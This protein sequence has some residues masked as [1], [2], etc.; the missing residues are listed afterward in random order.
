MNNMSQDNSSRSLEYLS[1]DMLSII[2]SF[3][4]VKDLEKVSLTSKKFNKLIK[5]HPEIL[6]CCLR[7]EFMQNYPEVIPQQLTRL[8]TTTGKRKFLIETI[9][10]IDEVKVFID[11]IGNNT[12]TIYAAKKVLHY[13][14]TIRKVSADKDELSNSEIVKMVLK[15]H[16]YLTSLVFLTGVLT[17]IFL[18]TAVV[19]YGDPTM[20]KQ[21]ARTLLIFGASSAF[22]C[23]LG[24]I[25][26]G[27]K[28]YKDKQLKDANE[29]IDKLD[30]E[31]P[32][33]INESN[34]YKLMQ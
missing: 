21:D 9:N 2:F 19:V 30:E 26:I 34:E 28:A 29:R 25:I 32:L 15:T 18:F 27:I 5:D 3:L 17:L 20:S 6:K 33:L 10:D 11:A 8:K 24:T 31:S 13:T 22:L 14:S 23:V 7:N 12:Q 16:C 1:P 4:E